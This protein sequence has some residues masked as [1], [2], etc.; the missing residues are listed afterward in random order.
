MAKSPVQ[1]PDFEKS[2]AELEGLVQR[3]ESGE[4]SLD[5][6][7]AC[8]KRGSSSPGIANPF[9]TRLSRGRTYQF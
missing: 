3:L 6:S 2:L 9:W 5:Q 8:F 7:L 4:L 1:R